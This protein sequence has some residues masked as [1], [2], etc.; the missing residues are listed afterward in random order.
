M[1]AGKKR[2]LNRNTPRGAIKVKTQG[3]Y[4]A[5]ATRTNSNL[6]VWEQSHFYTVGQTLNASLG[7]RKMVAA[8]GAKA[9]LQVK[10][11]QG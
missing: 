5:G 2:Q 7:K 8:R 11:G 9:V 3:Q 4:W 10:Q 1:S 6:F